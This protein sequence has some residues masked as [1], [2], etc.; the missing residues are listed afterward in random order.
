MV[1]PILL[2]LEDPTIEPGFVDTRN[3]LVFWARPP[4]KVKALVKECQ[5]KLREVVPSKFCLTSIPFSLNHWYP[6][7]VSSLSQT[8]SLVVLSLFFTSPIA[9]N[10]TPQN[11]KK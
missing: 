5:E 6:V 9:T 2:R 1:D 8:S 4:E 3:C 7:L 10:F 11:K